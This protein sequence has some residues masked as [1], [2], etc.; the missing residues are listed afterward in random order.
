MYPNPDDLQDK[1]FTVRLNKASQLFVLAMSASTGIP[2]AVIIRKAV[3]QS[4]AAVVGHVLDDR[5][6]GRDRRAA[7][8][9]LPGSY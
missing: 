2:P 9:A 1:V 4:R 8:Q 6:P 3:E 5:K 7:V